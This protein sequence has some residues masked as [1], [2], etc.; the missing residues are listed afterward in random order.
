MT[1]ISEAERHAQAV[2]DEAVEADPEHEQ[3]S[4]CWCCCISCSVN[5]DL[6]DAR[7]ELAAWVEKERNL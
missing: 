4:T 2:H 3:Y 5:P 1:V 6:D 7:A